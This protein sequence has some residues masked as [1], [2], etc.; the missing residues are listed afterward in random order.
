MKIG[1]IILI[2]L[3]VLSLPYG[4][5][6]LIPGVLLL[7]LD[8]KRKTENVTADSSDSLHS[9]IIT[10][11]PSLS[12]I[13]HLPADSIYTGGPTFGS[14]DTS[15][16]LA[17][18]QLVRFGRAVYQNFPIQS[19]RKGLFRITGSRGN[20]YFTSLDSCDC[21]DFERRNLPCKHIYA[22]AL[23]LGYTIDS[24]Y[25]NY[26]DAMCSDSV[27]PRPV[28]G[29]SNGL[30]Q[31]QVHGINPETKR[32]NKRLVYAMNETDAVLS[33]HDTGLLDPIEVDGLAD[34]NVF[35]PVDSVQQEYAKEYGIAV[36]PSADYYDMKSLLRRYA[37]SDTATVP[38]G[39]IKFATKRHVPCSLLAGLSELFDILLSKLPQR[40]QI[41]LYAAAV[42]CSL[43]GVSIGDVFE[44][45][46]SE[47]CFSFA[48]SAYYDEQLYR[49]I[50]NN[51]TQDAL[52]R[53]DK[54]SKQYRAVVNFFGNPENA[55]KAASFP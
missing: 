34:N 44:D 32:K 26:L 11:T 36:P 7:R 2:V 23:S 38:V 50:L 37:N 15:I 33:A 54:R 10:P 39:L 47:I 31:Y 17:E 55:K 53:P 9:G 3:G 48:D 8:K 14:W 52:V 16:H 6:L 42:Q 49:V 1:G 5:V 29:Y 25:S 4:L 41:A 40:D 27:I 45:P 18:G 21:K 20:I 13:R 28:T 30:R 43:N 24:F 22:L 35:L 12:E 51:L 19:F 46:V